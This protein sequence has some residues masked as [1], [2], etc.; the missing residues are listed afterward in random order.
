MWRSPYRLVG[1][2]K[3]NHILITIKIFN[4]QTCAYATYA[5]AKCGKFDVS[6]C[7]FQF[8]YRYSK[9][10]TFFSYHIV[11]TRIAKVTNFFPFWTI[12]ISMYQKYIL[13]YFIIPS[14]FSPQA[15]SLFERSRQRK[16][17]TPCYLS[18][19]FS[20]EH[21]GPYPQA[22]LYWAGRLNKLKTGPSSFGGKKNRRKN[23]RGKLRWLTF[24][25]RF[26]IHKSIWALK[27]SNII[28]T[29]NESENNRALSI[30][31]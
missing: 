6:Q 14:T 18:S 17:N 25:N 9:F 21:A 26:D 20:T 24:T 2:N 11:R 31:A 5:P 4:A 3:G 8:C 16:F 1:V 19:F 29:L 13:P 7:F 27:V 15:Y 30:F 28:L 23:W 12:G 10:D 22:Q